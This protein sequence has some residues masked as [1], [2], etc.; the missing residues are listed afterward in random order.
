[1]CV[2]F[3][4]DI[5]PRAALWLGVALGLGMLCKA[6]VALCAGAALLVYLWSRHGLRSGFFWRNLVISLAMALVIGAPWYG[7]NFALYGKFSPIESG[8][9]N[10]ALPN[11]SSGA[12]VMMMHDNFPPLFAMAHWMEFYSLW[13]QKDWFPESVRS[14]IYGLLA[15]LT[16]TAA[17]GNMLAWKRREP[18]TA[19]SRSARRAIYSGFALLWAAC[20]G[21]ALFVHWGWAEGGRYL[22]AS[23]GAVALF[24]ALGWRALVSENK[25]PAVLKSWIGFALVLNAICVYWLLTYLNPTFG[26]K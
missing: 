22:L 4:D 7:R 2:R 16:V 10:P 13:S 11:P 20:L 26:P 21:M 3:A 1:L 14:F 9:S 12:L 25:M 19:Q 23:V 8:Y 17:V 6:T 24:L 5:S 18:E 15:L